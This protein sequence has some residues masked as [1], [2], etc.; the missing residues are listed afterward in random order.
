MNNKN[1]NIQKVLF[2][3][4]TFLVG[5][6]AFTAFHSAFASSNPLILQ[7]LQNSNDPFFNPQFING[8]PTQ[9]LIPII[10]PTPHPEFITPSVVIINPEPENYSQ[11]KTAVV[12]L[13]DLSLDVSYS[14]NDA[15]L[16]RLNTLI[17]EKSPFSVL[18]NNAYL[19]ERLSTISEER[20]VPF[21]ILVGISQ[22]ESQIG[23][24]YAS[25]CDAGYYNWGG[26][27][28]RRIDSGKIIRDYPIPDEKGCWIY[29][30]NSVED[31]WISKAN[32]IRMGYLDKGCE[33]EY[34]MARCISRCYV[35]GCGSGEE[36]H[37]ID[38][39]NGFSPMPIIKPQIVPEGDFFFPWN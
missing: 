12:D 31:Y 26:V 9:P 16:K 22:A 3:L 34:D 14:V 35:G 24:D 28:A 10:E 20:N 11:P 39:V 5:I 7:Q 33:E 17:C 30:F 6:F 8:I 4:V 2:P 1:F 32:I 38:A 13:A 36:E 37:W 18:C 27:K 19:Q 23:V 29:K 15:E 21:W 25:G